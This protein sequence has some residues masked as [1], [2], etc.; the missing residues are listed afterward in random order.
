MKRPEILWPVIILLFLIGGTTITLGLLVA[1]N[2]DGGVQVVDNYY[3]KAVSWDSLAAITRSSNALG[4]TVAVETEASLSGRLGHVTVTDGDGV[5]VAGLIGRILVGRPQTAG[6]VGE[7]AM[8]STPANPGVY[9]FQFPNAAPGL[10]D[11][12]IDASI[13]E[14]RIVRQIRIEI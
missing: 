1:S 10:W 4:W 2:S 7:Y 8:Q 11:I 12:T 3:E 5:P 13:Q 9:R 6:F 14:K